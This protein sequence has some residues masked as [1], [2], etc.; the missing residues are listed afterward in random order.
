MAAYFEY[1]SNKTWTK[2][3]NICS[4]LDP[5]QV[6]LSIFVSKET[7]LID[8][9]RQKSLWDSQ[10]EKR[11]I[12]TTRSSFVLSPQSWDTPKFTTVIKVTKY[13]HL[14]KWNCHLSFLIFFFFFLIL[15]EAS[16]EVNHFGCLDSCSLL[17][18]QVFLLALLW[19]PFYLASPS[20]FSF[21]SSFA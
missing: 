20:S 17:G 21:A 1:I 3:T 6:D 18:F 7:L 10:V 8:I 12:L 13:L 19:F 9:S 4:N 14:I 15:S 5:S 2:L 11:V 16:H